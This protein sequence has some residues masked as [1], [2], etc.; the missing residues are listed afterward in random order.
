MI[1]NPPYDLAENNIEKIVNRIA[2]S[3]N[4]GKSAREM[5]EL[6]DLTI[7]RIIPSH[8]EKNQ[9][10]E[11]SKI[12]TQYIFCAP[13]FKNW[14]NDYAKA[15]PSEKSYFDILSVSDLRI[16][17]PH[18]DLKDITIHQHAIILEL[19]KQFEKHDCNCRCS[20]HSQCR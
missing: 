12:L 9:K 15:H 11:L 17:M 1:I 20:H 6:V 10:I 18:V 16:R 19:A 14:Y 2:Q 7:E 3:H 13:Y 4:L 5:Y 8:F